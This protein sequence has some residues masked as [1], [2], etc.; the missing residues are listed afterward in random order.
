MRSGVHGRNKTVNESRLTGLMGAL[1]LAL[2]FG[3]L[4]T[5]D[6]TPGAFALIGLGAAVMAAACV[7]AEF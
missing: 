7:I 2:M 3:L 1:C 6:A 4:W 5:G